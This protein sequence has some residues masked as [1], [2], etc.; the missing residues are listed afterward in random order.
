MLRGLISYCTENASVVSPYD[1]PAWKAAMLAF[2]ISGL[3]PNFFSRK[4]SVPSVGRWYS[5]DSS[6]SAN[7]FFARSASFLEMSKSARAVTV[8]EVSGSACTRYSASE[9]SSTGLVS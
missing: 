8:I 5:H 3:E 9:S 6:P 1:Q 4:A 2:M 7:M